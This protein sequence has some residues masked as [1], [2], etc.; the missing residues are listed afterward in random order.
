MRWENFYRDYRTPY[1]LSF[2]L[3]IFSFFSDE[4]QLEMLLSPHMKVISL[5][6]RFTYAGDDFTHS[7][8]SFDN[9]WWC[10]RNSSV[11]SRSLFLSCPR[12]RSLKSLQSFS[13]FLSRIWNFFSSLRSFFSGCFWDCVVNLKTSNRR[14]T[15]WFKRISGNW[16]SFFILSLEENH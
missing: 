8:I 11:L 13:F 15:D 4:K 12:N 9:D 7:S 16:M 6:V 2:K 5:S 14:Y 1:H 3:I 10:K